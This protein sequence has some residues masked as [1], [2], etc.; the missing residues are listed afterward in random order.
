[1]DTKRYH[2]I[3][4]LVYSSIFCLYLI[5]FIACS[6]SALPGFSSFYVDSDMHANL[7]WA[8]SIGEQGPLNPQPFHP[9]NEWMQSIAPFST[10][11]SWWGSIAVYQQSPLYA[12]F[13]AIILKCSGS[14]FAVHFSQLIIGFLLCASIGTL[15]E[16][17]SNNRTVGLIALIISGLYG[18]FYAYAWPL[19]RDLLSWLIISTFAL[20][21]IRWWR[22]WGENEYPSTWLS[23]RLGVVL[24]LGLLV[25]EIFYVYVIIVVSASGFQALRSR[26]YQPLIY[27]L[28]AF[29]VFISPL[30]IRNII[31]GAP[32]VSTS[33]RFAETF[34]EFNA[35]SAPGTELM[36]PFREMTY[37]LERSRGAALAVVRE[38]LA[39]Y[40][41]DYWPLL[42]KMGEKA[43]SLLDPFEAPDNVNIYYMQLISPVV[44]YALPHWLVIVPG[45]YGCILSLVK[46]DRR[47]I[48]FWVL[49]FCLFAN[50]ILFGPI[51]RYRQVLCIFWIPWAAYYIYFMVNQ[52]SRRRIAGFLLILIGCV[53]CTYLSPERTPKQLYRASEFNVSAE[54]YD[55]WGEPGKAQGQIKLYE[56]LTNPHG[57]N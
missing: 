34:I 8:E 53:L 37:I 46:H 48:W 10:W 29:L 12:Y 19:L 1:M 51:A 38:T 4:L 36:I 25:R 32:P 24:A 55:A 11:V 44:R 20:L 15:A 21:V 39:L 49:F 17:V 28:V 16:E 13:L 57:G 22:M 5:H 54:I 43:L 3:R 7:R 40:E 41:N 33:N 2:K 45:I 26:R 6:L 14:V 35:P 42:Q 47:W 52:S 31:A 56:K 9:Y 27:M 50:V 18:P 30:I 23:I